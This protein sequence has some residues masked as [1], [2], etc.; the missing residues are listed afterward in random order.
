MSSLRY[1]IEK[2]L[3]FMGKLE[4]TL[5]T[6]AL[7][8]MVVTVFLQ[9]FFRYVVKASLPF[10]EELARYLM[11]WVVY[12]GASIGAKEG[13]HIGVEAIVNLFPTSLK[14]IIVIITGILSVIFCILIIWLGFKVVFY[15]MQSGQRSPSME[16]PMFYAY[17]AVPVGGILMGIRFIEATVKNFIHFDDQ[18]VE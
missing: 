1:S 4:N 16:I 9:V 6:T 15:V 3:N 17:L 2:C 10:S 8:A 13:A 7:F 14:K 18:R 11:V 12:I 5:V